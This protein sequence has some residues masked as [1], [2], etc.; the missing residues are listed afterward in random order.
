MS[1]HRCLEWYSHLQDG[2]RGVKCPSS[3]RTQSPY[4]FL[5][6]ELSWPSLVQTHRVHTLPCSWVCNNGCR[7]DLPWL[8]AKLAWH[9]LVHKL[10]KT[11]GWS[12]RFFMYSSVNKHSTHLLKNFWKPRT[13]WTILCTE[14]PP[15]SVACI[16]KQNSKIITRWSFSNKLQSCCM[17]SHDMLSNSHPLYCKLWTSSLSSA[18][19]FTTSASSR[20]TRTFHHFIPPSIVRTSPY[21]FV[22]QPTKTK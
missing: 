20:V 19:C 21:S 2:I 15:Q 16:W 18:N 11:T 8:S 22:L 1:A 13:L 14:L 4:F 17:L 6:S 3:P 9:L 7:F 12:L 5:W 10:T